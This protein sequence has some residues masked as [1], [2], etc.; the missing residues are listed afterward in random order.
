MHLLLLFFYSFGIF[1]IHVQLLL[2]FGRQLWSI[3]CPVVRLS[4]VV[5]VGLPLAVHLDTFGR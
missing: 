1:K 2:L 5:A 4:T 3:V